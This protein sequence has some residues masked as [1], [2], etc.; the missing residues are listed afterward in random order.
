VRSIR[1]FW[2]ISGRSLLWTTIVVHDND[3][4]LL[5]E[6]LSSLVQWS[7]TWPMSFNPTKSV[8]LK[9]SNKQCPSDIK[10]YI[11]QH[12]IEQSTHATYLRVTIDKHFKWNKHVDKIVAKANA[13][14][15]FLKRNFSSCNLTV[16]KNCYLTMVQPILDYAC[17]VWSPYTQIIIHKLEMVQHQAVCFIMNSYSHLASVTEILNKL[18]L[19]S[20]SSRR[21]N[22]KLISY[23][24]YIY[25]Y[26]LI[27]HHILISNNDLTLLHMSTWG[28]Y[29]RY[30]RPSSRL[31]CHLHSFF[32]SAIKLW[33]NLLPDAV[34]TTS[35]ERF[36][37]LL[38]FS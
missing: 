12:Q 9:I 31:D 34:D 1:E 3:C 30:S 18:N 26:K 35:L 36:K 25:I 28:H 27:N 22:M 24:V 32:P 11:G 15:G 20:L 5:Q 29:Y 2:K 6:D 33:N 8:H 21:D 17:A 10:Y 19:P 37:Q 38:N 14:I 7:N 13:T 23:L 16:K 4:L